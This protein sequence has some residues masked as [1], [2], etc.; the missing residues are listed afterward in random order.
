MIII[1]QFSVIYCNF[2]I[3]SG[4]FIIYLQWEAMLITY[5]STRVITLPYDSI[6]GLMENS[7]HKLALLP[8]SSY[9]DDFKNAA[10]PLWRKAYTE[11]IQPNLGSYKAT[12]L[13]PYDH[14]KKLILE[15]PDMALY[16]NFGTY[17]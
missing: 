16:N 10:N 14:L 4:A 17:V 12:D 8:G 7:D 2:R 9:E 3:M 6:D 5:L 11:R 15:N 1:T 13:P